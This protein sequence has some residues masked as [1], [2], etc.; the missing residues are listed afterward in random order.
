MPLTRH[1]VTP[2]LATS[3]CR[4]KFL[5]NAQGRAVCLSSLNLVDIHRSSSRLVDL[6][7]SH[8]DSSM[9]AGG[10]QFERRTHELSQ[11]AF[12]QTV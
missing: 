9:T 8:F 1:Y 12:R 11:T 10:C 6:L 7:N 4:A 2:G 5:A 3:G